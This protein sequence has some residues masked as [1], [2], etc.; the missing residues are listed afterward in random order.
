MIQSSVVG[1]AIVA[2]IAVV[3]IRRW[4]LKLAI[5]SARVICGIWEPWWR[6]KL[7]ASS[8]VTHAGVV[9]AVVVAAVVIAVVVK[10]WLELAI[11]SARAICSGWGP[12]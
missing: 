7:T 5:R 6:C 8:G 9:C 11:R 2:T 1:A 10:G 4:W 12:W 3:V